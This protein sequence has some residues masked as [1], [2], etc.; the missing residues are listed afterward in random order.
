MA[1]AVEQ[2]LVDAAAWL[3]YRRGIAAT[4]VDAIATK[5]GV[6][7]PTLYARFGNKTALVTEVLTAAHLQRRSSLGEHLD[8]RAGLPA[9]Q[10]LLS[11]F[12]WVGAQQH[13]DWARGCQFVNASVELVRPQD[14]AARDVVARHKQWFRCVL[15]DLAAQA[16]A[17]EPAAVASQLHLLIEGANARM[18]TEADL[19]AIE[20]AS[21]VA[22]WLLVAAC[23]PNGADAGRDGS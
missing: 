22:R 20:V 7:K 13:G 19:G 11:V 5:S 1:S 2:R 10:R 15:G 21:Q 17:A 4:G 3:F 6:S 18:L 14:A 12:D 8:A 23:R 9:L 16:G